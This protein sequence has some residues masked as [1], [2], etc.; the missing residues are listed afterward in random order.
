MPPAC[1][2]LFGEVVLESLLALDPSHKGAL[3]EAFGKKTIATHSIAALLRNPSL[4][5]ELPRA[6]PPASKLHTQIA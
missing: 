2:V 5:K 3:L 1:V 6:F 4:K